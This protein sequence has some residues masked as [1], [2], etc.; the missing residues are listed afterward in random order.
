M[1]KGNF[2]IILAVFIVITTISTS[3]ID[4][5]EARKSKVVEDYYGTMVADPYRW[6]EDPE[7][8]ETINWVNAQNKI[9]ADFVDTPIREKIKDRYTKLYNYPKFSL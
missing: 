5:P 7:S 2:L 8:E 6:M 4:Y 1:K 9:T 3:A